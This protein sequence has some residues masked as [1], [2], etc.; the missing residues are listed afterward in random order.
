LPQQYDLLGNPYESDP[1]QPATQAQTV[2]SQSGSGGT[3]PLGNPIQSFDSSASQNVYLAV[4]TD[5]TKNTNWF[6]GANFK[7]IS[8]GFFIFVLIFIVL[9]KKYGRYLVAEKTNLKK[10]NLLLLLGSVCL[11][12]SSIFSDPY[13]DYYCENYYY[14][15][16][17]RYGHYKIFWAVIC[18]GAWV[19]LKTKHQRATWKH[20]PLAFSAIFI[21]KSLIDPH[22]GN[23]FS[24]MFWGLLLLGAWIYLMAPEKPKKLFSFFLPLSG[25]L[26]VFSLMVNADKEILRDFN[27]NWHLMAGAL[28]ALIFW[29][30]S[31]NYEKGP[32]IRNLTKDGH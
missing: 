13:E 9:G 25:V 28:L 18:L 27:A 8:L 14:E 11:S 12:L 6:V 22:H 21:F 17:W 4:G 3:D 24:K 20:T 26:I 1:N 10:W 30:F 23:G 31:I 29:T 2:T 5:A 19:F 32:E 7:W 15:Q 16:I